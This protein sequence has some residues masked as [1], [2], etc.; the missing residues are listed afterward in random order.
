LPLSVIL[1][2]ARADAR[3]IAERVT[4]A[5][6]AAAVELR[7]EVCD[8]ASLTAAARRALELGSTTIAAGGGDGTISAVAS[9]VVGT[10]A[11]LGVLPLGTLNHFARDMRI[12]I[13]LDRA[14]ATILADRV[15]SIDVGDVN[16]RVF[17]NNASV[18]LYPWLVW[19]R[20][21]RQ[22]QGRRKAVALAQAAWT[23]F[24]R[25]RRVTVLVR[26]EHGN[27]MRV[28][29]PFVFVGNNRYQL[30]GLDFGS[31]HRLDEGRLHVCMAPELSAAEMLGVFG[32]VLIGRLLDVERFESI[33]TSDLT[34]DAWRPRL[35]V[36]IDGE[37][38]VMPIPLQFEIRRRALRVAIPPDA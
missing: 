23:V 37:I 32:S 13:D 12:P 7:V 27:P 24:R 4:E 29:T 11:V 22:R 1:N 17:I 30:S 6:R 19:E 8:G 14:I 3:T 2:S 21:Q 16:G 33:D 25:Y 31:R 34:I 35:G 20:Q 36:A 18:G 26:H 5:A 28:R 10:N 38:T 9:V 15:A